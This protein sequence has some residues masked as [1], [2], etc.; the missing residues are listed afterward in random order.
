MVTGVEVKY[1]STAIDGEFD[2][3]TAKTGSVQL[4]AAYDSR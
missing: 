4:E 2:K 3:S 1:Y